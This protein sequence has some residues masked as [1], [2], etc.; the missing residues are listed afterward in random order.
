M[1]PVRN[2]PLSKASR[3]ASGRFQYSLSR[4]SDLI[5]TSPSPCSRITP[6]SPRTATSVNMV[7][8]PAEPALRS[9]SSLSSRVPPP[10]DSVSA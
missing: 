9:A 8:R 5:T 7:A 10:Q 3:V 6:S 1:S 2:Q 4:M